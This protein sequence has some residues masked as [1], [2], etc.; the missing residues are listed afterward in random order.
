MVEADRII[1][2]SLPICHGQCTPSWIAG[3]QAGSLRFR[4][5]EISVALRKIKMRPNAWL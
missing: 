1:F 5:Q 3:G 2:E 4:A